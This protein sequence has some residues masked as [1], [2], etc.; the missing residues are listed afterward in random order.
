MRDLDGLPRGI[1]V[2][3]RGEPR[4]AVGYRDAPTD[5]T[6][7]ITRRW[8]SP[9]VVLLLFFAVGWDAF[10]VLW[11]AGASTAGS[12]AMLLFPILHV[13]AG[14]AVT[15]G[16]LAGLLNRTYIH[17]A[18]GVVD[19]CHGP[20]PW[21]GRQRIDVAELSQLF[22]E[23]VVRRGKH[24]PTVHYELGAVVRD[25]RRTLL[26]DL[27]SHEQGEALERLIED[28]LGIADRPVGGE[29]RG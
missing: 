24:G 27:P 1:T 11:Y 23:R 5:P 21:S 10:L 13:V 28:H 16:A 22:V 15:Y 2:E 17:V 18:H 7:T 3:R 29:P 14:V 8:F 6:L 26:K 9:R 20:L 19:I 4:R 12:M 25:C